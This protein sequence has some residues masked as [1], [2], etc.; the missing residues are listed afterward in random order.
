V[1]R[2]VVSALETGK[3]L[4]QRDEL[5]RILDQISYRVDRAALVERERQRY[6]LLKYLMQKRRG[7][8]FE[9]V[10]LQKFPRFHLVQILEFGINAALST[11]NN[12][13]LNP[14][15]RAIIR[16]EKISPREDKLSL[17]LVRLV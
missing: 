8:E 7:D 11:P 12:L 5:E 4:L 3:P 16:I 14:Y 10:V 17:G 9:A 1:Q 13:A 15:D 6:F 2:Q